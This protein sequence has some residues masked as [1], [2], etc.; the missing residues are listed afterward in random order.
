MKKYLVYKIINKINDNCYVGIHVTENINDNYM[1]SG[2]N[3]KKAIK[4]YGLENFEKIL[5]FQFDNKKEM[6]DKEAELVNEEFIA[7]PD[8]YNI[9]KGGGQFLTTDTISIKDMDENYFRVHKTDPRYLSGELIPICKNKITVKDKSGKTFSV[10]RDDSRYLSGELI[11]LGDMGKNKIPVQNKLKKC[12][13]VDKNDP[14]YLSGELKHIMAGL[15]TVRDKNGK[16]FSVVDKNDPRYLSGELVGTFTGLKHTEKAKKK[17]GQKN[18]VHQKGE[19]NSQYGT[20][21]ITNGNKN[22][23]INKLDVIPDNWEKGRI[24]INNKRL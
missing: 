8:T 1:G 22:K 9:I 15:I 3:I 19:G 7:R 14:R 16:T 4:E 24:I 17:I 23:K 10:N 5:L 21:W 2:N 18:S 13:F 12:F 20:M 6:F 11:T